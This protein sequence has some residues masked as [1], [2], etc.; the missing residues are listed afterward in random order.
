MIETFNIF[1]EF[2][3]RLNRFPQSF[4]QS[5][6]RIGESIQRLNENLQIPAEIINKTIRKIRKID[7]LMWAMENLYGRSRIVCGRLFTFNRKISKSSAF[8]NFSVN[9]IHENTKK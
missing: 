8:D 9:K 3:R 7:N 5:V 6:N 1:I 4:A 2:I